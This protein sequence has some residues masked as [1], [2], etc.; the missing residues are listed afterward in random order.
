MRKRKLG[1][2]FRMR[3]N[4][5]KEIFI[6]V[7]VLVLFAPAWLFL[8]LLAFVVAGIDMLASRYLFKRGDT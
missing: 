4:E 3:W 2:G 1:L 5:M 8:L 7:A 6:A